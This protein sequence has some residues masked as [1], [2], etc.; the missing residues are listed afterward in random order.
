MA[1][2][3][4]CPSAERDIS[5]RDLAQWLKV[6]AWLTLG[7]SPL[8]YLVHGPPVSAEQQAIQ[9]VLVTSAALVAAVF[10][11]Q[12]GLAWVRRRRGPFPPA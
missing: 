5:A 9:I 10:G 7:F 2:C 1:E 11:V 3:D 12:R 4:P 6:W 8:L